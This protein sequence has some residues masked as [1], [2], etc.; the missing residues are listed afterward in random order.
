MKAFKLHNPTD[1][2]SALA[3][4]DTPEARSGATRV[5]AGGQD[6]LTEMKEHLAEPDAL[7]NLKHIPGLDQVHAGADGSLEIGAL[8]TLAALEEHAEVA[9]RLPALAQAAGVVASAQIRSQ[10]TLGGNLNQR[11]RCWYFRSE[12]APCLKKGGTECF[13]Y[14]GMSKYN[15][16]LGGGPSYIVHP[17]DLAPALV[18]LGASAEIVSAKGSRTVAL[19][20][21]F[22]L[23][24]ESDVKRETVL[25]PG[26]ILRRVL[27]PAPAANT[28][29]SYTK[30]R[31]KG[32]FD[33]ALASV[34]LALVLEGGT[35][36]SSRVVLGG[37]APIPWRS[38]AAEAA[39]EGGQPSRALFEKAA[40]ASVRG[41]EALAHN[42]YKVPLAKG[43][44]IR[45]L[46]E[47]CA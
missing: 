26:E 15:A 47:L 7:V 41:A 18:A 33:F 30:F 13:S 14:G 28:R 44:V 16:I 31:E 1:L 12:H 6:L 45:A 34:A 36:R 43:L 32:S 2:E 22:T 11:P 21:Y 39:L 5:L 10:A 19:E 23:P 25:Q 9:Q 40:A 38:K 42:G 3:L 20:K 4:L 27:V 46:E 24:S 17:S 8:C 37:V 35:I 29:S